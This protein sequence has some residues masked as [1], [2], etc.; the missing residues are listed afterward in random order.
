M[1]GVNISTMEPGVLKTSEEVNIH[2][3][4][5]QIRMHCSNR[6][7]FSQKQNLKSKGSIGQK[8]NFTYNMLRRRNPNIKIA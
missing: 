1:K 7:G 6:K 4:T 2:I 3:G 8:W 5:Q